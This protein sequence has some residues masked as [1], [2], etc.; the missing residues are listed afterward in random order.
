MSG[1]LELAAPKGVSE[2]SVDMPVTNPMVTLVAP[3]GFMALAVVRTV[4]R[5]C[6]SAT[7]G[8]RFL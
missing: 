4:S 7:I 3:V 8:A 1:E 2:R 5:F 6:V